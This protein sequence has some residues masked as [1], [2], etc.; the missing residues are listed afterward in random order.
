MP[1]FNAN[2]Q[3]A[4]SVEMKTD[5]LPELMG[6]WTAGVTWEDGVG[7]MQTSNTRF[8]TAYD[9][10]IYTVNQATQSIAEVIAT[11]LK[12]L[13]AL[14]QPADTEQYYGT[15]ITVDEAGNFLVGMDFVLRPASSLNWTVFCTDGSSK[16]ITLDVPEGW[17]IGRTDCVGRVLGDLTKEAYFA[18]VPENGAYTP[19]LR[20]IKVT[21][22]GTAE[23]IKFEDAGSADVT[24]Y[25]PQTIAQ[26]VYATLAEAKAAGAEK[27][28][29]YASTN[30]SSSYY[31]E[32]QNG[33]KAVEIL[34]DM[35]Y[36]TQSGFNGFNTF[37]VDGNRYF[38]RDLSTTPGAR[39][40]SLV[41][42]NEKGNAVAEWTNEGY[43]DNGGFSSIMP[44]VLD[45]KTVEICYYC[46]GN[47]YGAAAKLIFDP[48][49]AHEPVVPEIPAGANEENP[50]VISTTE[51]L[52]N[53]ATNMKSNPFYVSL[54]ND[55]DMKDV[56]FSPISNKGTVI[57]FRGNNHVIN[58]L[59]ITNNGG[60]SALFIDFEGSISNLGL[61]NVNATNTNSWGCTGTLTAY[62]KGKDVVIE[63]CY[64]TGQAG[65][66]FYVGGLVAGLNTDASLTLRNCY[67][68]VTTT[69]LVANNGSGIAGGLV[70][71]CN[72]G[73]ILTVEN[74]V[75]YGVVK[76]VSAAS[77]IGGIL[78]ANKGKTVTLNNVVVMSPLVSGA[79]LN[80]VCASG[81]VTANNVYLWNDMT[82]VLDN[83]AKTTAELQEIITSWEGFNSKLNDG[84]AV[85]AWQ[86]A[87]GVSTLNAPEIPGT[88]VSPYAITTA[89]EL[90]AIKSKLMFGYTYFTIENDIDMEGVA[91]TAPIDGNN[92][93]GHYIMVDGKNHVI[94]NLTTGGGSN[95]VGGFIGILQ[96]EVR[97][98]GLEN[99]N[100]THGWGAGAFGGMT[101]H[102]NYAP[103]SVIEN[104][105]VTGKVA[106]TGA[107]YAG[108]FG[109][110]NNGRLKI[111]NSYA[112]VDVTGGAYGNAGVIGWNNGGI[113]ELKNVYVSGKYN[114][115][116]AAGIAYGDGGKVNM[117][118]V[119][120]YNATIVG[121]EAYTT[122]NDKIAGT[123]E[124]VIIGEG[125]TVNKA[126]VE[127]GTA[128]EEMQKTIMSWEGYNK[129]MVNASN[130]MP[131]LAWQKDNVVTGIDDIIS[132]EA[133]SNAPAVYYNL[134]GVR[135]DNPANGVY[136]VRKGNKTS[137]VLV[138]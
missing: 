122:V 51:D 24:P 113:T 11:G 63:N 8:A 92:F 90:A 28:F 3:E 60:N 134:Q 123:A 2:A 33:E 35:K 78:G 6:K 30:G 18:I 98:L 112:N 118:N 116:K 57:Y 67:A 77:Q 115:G 5:K 80:A 105:F 110:Y 124:G 65:N 32:I 23:S 66:S 55:I 127:N 22:D 126:A 71:C 135:V 86:E 109:G 138:K 129:T 73:S 56:K 25:C 68:N 79:T 62:V 40:M 83:N 133:D 44:R 9:G 52:V 53:L 117:N 20:I 12:D 93:T 29:Y 43:E 136:I 36:A 91:Y 61:E 38:I 10:K 85:L 41:I 74:C 88:K 125:T 87:N 97:N 106:S 82:C 102:T 111:I 137:K 72:A 16:Q 131:V 31:V 64:A 94:K 50:Y 89:A 101:G 96:G 95:L 128:T 107:G 84:Y 42:T 119:A 37:V 4:I 15:A 17:S 100:V 132:D 59:T 7:S 70:G 48:A 19:K 54:A 75:N 47:Q 49:K 14:P 26:P 81:K 76:S 13:Y 58:N 103:Y 121:T 120:L 99:I 1:A 114:G 104:C 45:N 108:G 46:A 34:P 130:Q 27:N 69:A 39:L 21:G